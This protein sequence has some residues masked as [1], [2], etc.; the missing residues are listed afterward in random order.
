MSKNSDVYRSP[1]KKLSSSALLDDHVGERIRLRPKRLYFD[2]DASILL[3]D[4][5]L[6]GL[7]RKVREELL[8]L[9]F[10]RYASFT[11]DLEDNLV[12]PATRSLLDPS[13]SLPW[14][15]C[16]ESR[17]SDD[18]HRILVEEVVHGL[19][20]ARLMRAVRRKAGKRDVEFKSHAF[21]EEVDRMAR[22]EDNLKDIIRLVAV[23][24]TETL[25]TT[26]LA[27]TPQSQA[28]LQKPVQRF[29]RGHDRDERKHRY[30]FQYV[31]RQLWPRLSAAQKESIG[32]LL[33]R[34]L[35]VYLTL[36][37]KVF[38]AILGKFPAQVK[39]PAGTVERIATHPGIQERKRK[40]AASS[41]T[42]IEKAGAMTRSTRRLCRDLGLI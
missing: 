5:A 35:A 17:Q 10:L 26:A 36:D 28:P 6:R 4:E 3:V 19:E 8:M 41:I 38:E 13:A 2:P 31:F 37:R 21:L 22:E 1:F 11:S 33:P 16:R 14:R 23:C 40:S 34:M 30:Y 27:V 39:D 15:P 42:M 12:C 29:F 24:L 25:I 7:S 18:A 20:I 32:P 9:E